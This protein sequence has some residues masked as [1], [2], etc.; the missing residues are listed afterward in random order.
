M[1][2]TPTAPTCQSEEDYSPAGS[3]RGKL[4]SPTRLNPR[5]SG[6]KKTFSSLSYHHP[7]LFRD[8]HCSAEIHVLQ[9]GGVE[10]AASCFPEHPLQLP[11]GMDILDLQLQ[12][13]Q[14]PAGTAVPA[15][16]QPRAA[17]SP[18]P[19]FLQKYLSPALWGLWDR[20][21]ASPTDPNGA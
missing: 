11:A 8:S 2:F 14:S 9:S 18:S 12:R 5:G 1:T 6:R 7:S 20:L 13:G 10:L 4:P 15:A 16:G 21:L 3:K 17:S 19:P